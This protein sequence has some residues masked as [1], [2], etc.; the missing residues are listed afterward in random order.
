MG[1]KNRTT[2]YDPVTEARGYLGVLASSTSQL[3][4]TSSAASLRNLCT[5]NNR[6]RLLKSFSSP[7][8][9]CLF[10]SLRCWLEIDKQQCKAI[11]AELVC[12]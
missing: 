5:V 8:A 12:C 6:S 7:V 1:D 4:W 3:S 9:R 2:C 10:I 11:C